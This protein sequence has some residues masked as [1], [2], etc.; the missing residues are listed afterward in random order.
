[1]RALGIRSMATFPLSA[2]GGS[3]GWLSFG[4][5]RRERAWIEP[6]IR[7]LR[8]VAGVSAKRASEPA[9]HRPIARR[10]RTRTAEPG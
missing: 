7:R 9:G 4:S 2:A 3:L 5:I 8:L 6:E 1:L 10:L